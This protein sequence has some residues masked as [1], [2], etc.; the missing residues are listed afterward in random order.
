MNRRAGMTMLELMVTVA[1]LTVVMG[2]LF[3][4]LGNVTKFVNLEQ[5]KA[6]SRD[7]A[8]KALSIITR[9][10][11]QAQK[12]SISTLPA[13]TISYKVATDSDGNGVAVNVQG[14]IELSGTRTIMR[15][16]QDANRD[17]QTSR[18]LIM[19]NGTSVQVLANNVPPNEDANLNGTLDTGEDAN[20]N[21]ILDLGAWFEPDGRGV[22]I[23]VQSESQYGPT[24]KITMGLTETVVPRN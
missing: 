23:T 2:A 11:R 9:D 6:N 1:V 5:A 24:Q 21:G 17:G 16:T 13:A 8:R 12:V 19:T 4:M 20:N 10:L 18:Q 14:R 7:E 3:G 22:R 15:D